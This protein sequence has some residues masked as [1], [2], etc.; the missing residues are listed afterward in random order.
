MNHNWTE[1]KLKDIIDELNNY[2]SWSDFFDYHYL[3]NANNTVK[4][5]HCDKCLYKYMT[6]NY[7]SVDY[8]Y[9]I[10]ANSIKIIQKDFDPDELNCNEIIIKNLLE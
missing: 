4:I 10:R 5:I 7:N 9:V 6:I 8:K 3:K 2:G 1:V